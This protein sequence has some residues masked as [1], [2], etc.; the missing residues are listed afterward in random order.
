MKII[1]GSTGTN[2]VTS[3][4]DGEFNQALFGSENIVLANGNKLSAAIL[5][6]NTINV[7]DGDLL[8]QGRHALIEPGMTED[9]L[10]STGALNT[11][12]NDLIVARYALN[13]TTGYESITLEVI[14]GEE[15]SETAV[16]PEY[17]TGDIRTGS[18]QVDFP[19]YRVSLSGVTI[20]ALTPLFTAESYSLKD[21]IKNELGNKAAKSHTHKKADIT[22]FPTSLPA[23][24]VSAWAKASTK[25]TYT[26]TE[27]G[28]MPEYTNETA[29]GAVSTTLNPDTEYSFT[30]VT[31]LT[32]SPSDTLKSSN[33]GHGAHGFVGFASSTPT[34]TV[35][36]F[37]YSDG[38]TI[39]SASAS[40]IWEFD[41]KAFNGGTYI[42]WKKWK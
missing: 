31:S 11:Y 8:L 9:V 5:D 39:T 12:R 42:L 27:V 20:S 6:N 21:Y 28:A 14:E 33:T 13:T 38:D 17:S 34:I 41:V 3:N 7:K 10:I 26:Y 15:S 32:L 40:G 19:L 24:D 35:S 16:D 2:H 25:P 29:T 23:S 37:D 4:N 36:G 22:D 1:T 30:E 18:T